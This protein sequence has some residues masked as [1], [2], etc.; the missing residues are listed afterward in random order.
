MLE[1][2]NTLT[3][4]KLAFYGLITRPD[5]AEERITELEDII[6]EASKSTE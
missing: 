4:I 3:E 1:M 2:K 5:T 6:N